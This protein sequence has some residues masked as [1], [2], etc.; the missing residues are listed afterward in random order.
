MGL[1]NPHKVYPILLVLLFTESQIFHY[2][3]RTI[4]HTSG[5]SRTPW[6]AY[7]QCLHNSGIN[8]FQNCMSIDLILWNGR[9][10][11]FDI[12]SYTVRPICLWGEIFLEN[13][14]GIASLALAVDISAGWL[15]HWAS[16]K[17]RQMES[18]QIGRPLQLHSSLS[19]TMSKGPVNL[20]G[21][22]RMF[23]SESP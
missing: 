9:N 15:V 10:S 14:P 16:F 1:S 20:I 6:W 19:N 2:N 21:V 23:C 22:V 12:N 7:S 11:Q 13:T 17:S 4:A 3:F 8:T 18:L 5:I